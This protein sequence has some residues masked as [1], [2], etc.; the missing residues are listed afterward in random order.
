MSNTDKETTAFESV[1]S[2]PPFRFSVGPN[3][4]EFFI[5]SAVIAS[6]S[7]PL[8]N[9]VHG[10][11]SEAKANHA[12]L[13]TVDELTFVLFCEYAYTGNYGVKT[14]QPPPLPSPA[15][16][17][18]IAFWA[19]EIEKPAEE[20]VE[21]LPE[22]PA[23]YLLEV[24]VAPEEPVAY[25]PEEPDEIAVIPRTTKKSKKG[26]KGKNLDDVEKP[27]DCQFA[28]AAWRKRDSM[29]A[30]FKGKTYV[31]SDVDLNLPPYKE[32]EFNGLKNFL[33]VHTKVYLLADCYM[34]S[35]LASLSIHRLHQCL[36]V[37]DV[38][39]DTL[40][41]IVELLRFTFEEE[42]PDLL[43]QLVSLFT[44]CYIEKLWPHKGFKDLLRTYED[45][46]ERVIGS[47]LDRL[48]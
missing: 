40:E 24:P 22:E 48:D 39:E 12:V 26:K 37:Y 35:N 5:H 45:L 1:F 44:A 16:P 18:V 47:T 27:D 41:D 13:D 29:W 36:C 31:G 9:L 2:S 20:P 43:R 14:D 38:R 4:R 34:I 32:T 23:A 3:G 10:D 25:L 33:L 42:T 7:Q 28:P 46:F 15:A 8:Y 17:P 30:K 6:Q 19:Q 21:Y 11:F